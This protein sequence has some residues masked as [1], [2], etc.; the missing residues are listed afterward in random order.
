MHLANLMMAKLRNK[1]YIM[2]HEVLGLLAP[3][4]PARIVVLELFLVGRFCANGEQQLIIYHLR[5]NHI[6]NTSMQQ[7]SIANNESASGAWTL[8]SSVHAIKRF[9]PSEI[10]AVSACWCFFIPTNVI[11]SP[12]AALRWFYFRR[13]NNCYLLIGTTATL[14]EYTHGKQ[15]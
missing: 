8:W 4:L 15:S 2:E 14:A 6:I 7:S 3:L 13:I 11:S 9:R 10:G 5:R 12:M 1:H